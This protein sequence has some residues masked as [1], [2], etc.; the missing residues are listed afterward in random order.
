MKF[1]A[2]YISALLMGCSF[3]ISE[4][5][6]H[7]LLITPSIESRHYIEQ[8][9]G[10]LRNSQAVKL[11]DNVF[12]KKSTITI[13]RKQAWS[14]THVLLNERDISVPETFTLLIHNQKCYIRHNQTEIVRLLSRIKCKENIY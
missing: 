8:I 7:A 11:A 4:H 9:I 12:T 1:K 5:S 14:D 2:Y 6:A 3:N 13:A 10:N